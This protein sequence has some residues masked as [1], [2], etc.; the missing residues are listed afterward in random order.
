MK[1]HFHIEGVSMTVEELAELLNIRPTSIRHRL[2][3]IQIRPTL[4]HIELYG[5]KFKLPNG[6]TARLGRKGW[7]IQYRGQEHWSPYAGIGDPPGV[8][9]CSK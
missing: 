8:S 9:T 2:A 6:N 5:K 4:R 7:E 1:T 3:M